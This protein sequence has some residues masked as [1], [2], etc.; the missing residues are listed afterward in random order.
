MAVG[1]QASHQWA[2]LS[3]GACPAPSQPPGGV[4]RP[5][6]HT[7][8]VRQGLNDPRGS[9]TDLSAVEGRLSGGTQMPGPRVA[10]RRP[11]RMLRRDLHCPR[12]A[13]RQEGSAGQTRPRYERL[14]QE[15]SCPW[16]TWV[17]ALA[18]DSMGKSVMVHA[19]TAHMGP[20]RQLRPWK[21]QRIQPRRRPPETGGT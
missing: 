12:E 11:A 17:T 9:W 10:L 5:L 18:G 1:L 16:G 3:G 8:Q 19:H 15:G 13:I 7:S 21:L 4:A 20:A 2:P 6:P 14:L